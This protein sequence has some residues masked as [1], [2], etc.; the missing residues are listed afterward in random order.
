MQEDFINTYSYKVYQC[1]IECLIVL[2]CTV[3]GCMLWIKITSMYYIC[4]PMQCFYQ[5]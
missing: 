1:K 5:F 2:K 3:A 4:F